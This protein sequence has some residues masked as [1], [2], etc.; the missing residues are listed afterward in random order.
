MKLKEYCVF[1]PERVYVLMAIARKKDN[2]QVTTN[3]EPVFREVLK[4]EVDVERKLQRLRAQAREYEPDEGGDLMWRVYI[5]ANARNVVSA[6][7]HFHS[8]Q[9]NW[10]HDLYLGD[11]AV[12]DKLKKVG[13]HW[14]SELQR[15][16][17]RDEKLF[18]H[19]LDDVDM[20]QY[21]DFYL[22]IP[23]TVHARTK[24]P[25]GYHIVSDP[26]NYTEWRHPVPFELKTD[27]LLH[28]E[29]IA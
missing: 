14:M 23:T 27:G 16:R 2:E 8:H 10:A 19:D 11:D 9:L 3:T 6:F 24:T 7:R 25:N 18:L 29:V 22:D 4:D 15:P 5:T 17:N 26:F 21:R 28:V 1:G 13:S 12:M 20:K